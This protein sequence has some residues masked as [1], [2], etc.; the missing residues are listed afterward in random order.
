[1]DADRRIK[2]AKVARE[3]EVLILRKVLVGEDQHCVFSE[4]IFNREVIGWLLDRPREIN[5]S[6]LSGKARRNRKNADG[7]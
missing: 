4:G 1:M 7:H 2:R 5:V 6:D 3:I